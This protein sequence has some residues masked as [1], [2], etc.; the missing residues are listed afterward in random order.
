MHIP[1]GFLNT[2]VTLA[3][4]GIAA[5]TLAYS[6]KKVNQSIKPEQIPLMGLLASFV[7]MIQLF[8]F[9]IGAGTSIHLTGALFVSIL[10]GPLAGFIIMTVSLLALA[11]LFQHGGI[12]SLG[13]NI[14]NMAIIGCF[15][16]YAIYRILPGKRLSLVAAGVLSGVL[17]AIL[18]AFELSLSGMLDLSSA[19]KTMIL[20]YGSTGL[21]E[22][23]VTVLILNFLYKVKPEL[24]RHSS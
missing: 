11:I 22:G 21:I 8:S 16:A 18:C 6:L 23:I 1:D 3:T 19:L 12:F 4:S 17:S 24:L 20:I 15:F 7:F 9:P 14:L 5:A 10:L 2:P 13:A